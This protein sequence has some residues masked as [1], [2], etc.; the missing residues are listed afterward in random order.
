[1]FRRELKPSLFSGMPVRVGLRARVPRISVVNTASPSFNRREFVIARAEVESIRQPS[2]CPPSAMDVSR[3]GRSLR[4]FHCHDDGRFF[5]NLLHQF[6]VERPRAVARI[7]LRRCNRRF[8]RS[9]HSGIF[10]RRS[11]EEE[12]HPDARRRV[13]GGLAAER[14][15]NSVLQTEIRPSVR[16]SDF[17]RGPG[18]GGGD[19]YAIGAVAEGENRAEAGSNAAYRRL[20]NRIFSHPSQTIKTV[21]AREQF[22]LRRQKNFPFGDGFFVWR[23]RSQ[24][25]VMSPSRSPV[26][27]SSSG[28]N[29]RTRHQ[30][31]WL[32]LGSPRLV[33]CF[34]VR[35]RREH[36]RLASRQMSGGRFSNHD[37]GSRE[38][39]PVKGMASLIFTFLLLLVRSRL[40]PKRGCGPGS[41]NSSTP[42]TLVFL[43]VTAASRSGLTP[44]LRRR[45]LN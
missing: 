14:R 13:A 39:S 4:L 38:L 26:P 15:Q 16:S 45:R 7:K 10:H 3:S 43:S 2:R 30:R 25:N 23:A 29:R 33:F 17:Q 27:R 8:T 32:A 42:F 20:A 37:A 31:D 28:Q 41:A 18:P 19:T 34:S 11:A 24:T 9:T 36:F 44:T 5:R 6:H 1:M 22:N 21:R 35:L 12:F 40:S